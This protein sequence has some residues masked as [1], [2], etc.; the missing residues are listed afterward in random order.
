MVEMHYT[1]I[2]L[3]IIYYL[4]YIYIHSIL[5][6]G[7]NPIVW[8]LSFYQAIY[9]YIYIYT[10]IHIFYFK[11]SGGRWSRTNDLLN[12]RLVH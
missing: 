6:S 8:C 2:M 10:Y 3:G 4:R 9:I 11:I 12:T 5:K 7:S 1:N